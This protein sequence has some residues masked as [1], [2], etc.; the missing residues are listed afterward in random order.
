MFSHLAP[1][2]SS[3]SV[4]SLGKYETHETQAPGAPV[5]SHPRSQIIVEDGNIVPPLLNL[6]CGKNM[7]WKQ[8]LLHDMEKFTRNV[9]FQREGIEGGTWLDHGK[10]TEAFLLVHGH[11][12]WPTSQIPDSNELQYPRD[13]E[14]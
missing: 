8:Q 2:A 7:S 9:H 6:G 12:H 11:M 14:K 10:M 3:G 13:E 4:N 5:L 1:F